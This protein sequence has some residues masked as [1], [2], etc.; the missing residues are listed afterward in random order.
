MRLEEACKRV[1]LKRQDKYNCDLK[2]N[3]Y[4]TE[5][6]I[7]VLRQSDSLECVFKSRRV[8]EAAGSRGGAG[9]RVGGFKRPRDGAGS[10]VGGFKRPRD[11]GF[12]SR[13]VQESAGSRVGRVQESAGFKSRRVQESARSSVSAFKS[14]R[15]QESARSRVSAFKSQRVRWDGAFKSPRV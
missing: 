5:V 12:K 11:G 7:F 8:Q 15:V 6:N 3:V 13:R 10:R 2:Y 1:I 9:S 4:F 14:Q